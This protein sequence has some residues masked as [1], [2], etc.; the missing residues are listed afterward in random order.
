M[1][2]FKKIVYAKYKAI[3]YDGTIKNYEWINNTIAVLFQEGI[4]TSVRI[5]FKMG[6]ISCVCDSIDEFKQH[7]YGQNIEVS[8]YVLFLYQFLTNYCLS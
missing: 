6:D 2:E 7:A 4:E 5:E 1:A 8:S 3:D